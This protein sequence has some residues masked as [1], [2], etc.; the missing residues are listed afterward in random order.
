VKTNNVPVAM[1][2]IIRNVISIMRGGARNLGLSFPTI[3]E[4]GRQLVIIV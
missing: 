4:R 3:I 1:I 2:P